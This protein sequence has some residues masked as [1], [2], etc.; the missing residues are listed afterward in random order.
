LQADHGC[1]LDEIKT[2]STDQVSD[3]VFAKN[4]VAI[5]SSKEKELTWQ[6]SQNDGVALINEKKTIELQSPTESIR[7]D[8]DA[9]TVR[10]WFGSQ[11][12]VYGYQTIKNPE[13]GNRDVFFINK[14]SVE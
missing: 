8:D 10:H 4:K 14:I 9:A 11:M 5:V 7:S 1:K 6:I 2:V 12:I 3:F 13:K